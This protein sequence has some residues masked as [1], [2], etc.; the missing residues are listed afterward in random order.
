MCKNSVL[1]VFRLQNTSSHDNQLR[2]L[3]YVLENAI[4]SLPEDQ[5]QM[6]CLIDFTGWSLSNSPIKTA[7]ETANILQCH[8]PERLAVGFLYNPPRIFET[9]W[10]AKFIYPKN[11]ESMELM[12]KHFDL[13]VLP[14]EFGGRNQVQYNH[15]EFSKMMIAE[16]TITASFWSLEEKTPQPEVAS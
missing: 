4:L 12:R 9:F 8:Y 10:K 6:V 15:E 13:D 5:E 16:D 14:V 2:H 1:T 11:K 7:R 3:V